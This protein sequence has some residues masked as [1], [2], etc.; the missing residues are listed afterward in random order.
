MVSSTRLPN[1]PVLT[2]LRALVLLSGLSALPAEA[3]DAAETRAREHFRAGQQAYEA[4]KYE[5]ALKAFS[6]AY[7]LHPLPGLL[8]NIAQCHRKLGNYD[9]AAVFYQQYLE[10]SRSR[11]NFSAVRALLSEVQTA[12]REQKRKNAEE[13][14]R[15]RQIKLAGTAD[16]S[17]DLGLKEASAS[18]GRQAPLAKPSG[19]SIFKKWWFWTGVGVLVAGTTAYLVASHHSSDPTLGTV[20]TR[21]GNVSAR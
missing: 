4:R 1:R 18:P 8:F 16:A 9:R 7:G 20:N 17:R 13:A 14:L 6:E 21:L 19:D 15:Q 12:D 2:G 3:R 11:E 5:D 10:L